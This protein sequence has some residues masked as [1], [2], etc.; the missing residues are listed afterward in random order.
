M[1]T[2]SERL[3]SSI[4]LGG[5]AATATGF[6]GVVGIA[7]D[8]AVSGGA[9]VLAGG[10]AATLTPVAVA[11]VA[12]ALIV[13]GGYFI[14]STADELINDVKASNIAKTKYTIDE[15]AN[16]VT[17]NPDN[18]AVL[19]YM[20]SGINRMFTPTYLFQAI[21]PDICKSITGMERIKG[22]TVNTIPPTTWDAFINGFDN[23]ITKYCK[24]ELAVSNWTEFKSSDD[25]NTLVSKFGGTKTAYYSICFTMA[26]SET[27][28]GFIIYRC[29][30]DK[31]ATLYPRRGGFSS[32]NAWFGNHITYK[33]NPLPTFTY[34]DTY[35]TFEAGKR[36]N[37][38][39]MPAMY[40]IDSVYSDDFIYSSA[41]TK[42]VS[43]APFNIKRNE[44]AG[45]DIMDYISEF[46]EMT[47]EKLDEFT[48]ALEGVGA[49]VDTL[50]GA[51]TDITGELEE[52]KSVALALTT[53]ITAALEREQTDVLTGEMEA[54]DVS[55]AER[56]GVDTATGAAETT[57]PTD[58]DN[59]GNTPTV[60]LPTDTGG[61]D[62]YTIYNPTA[63]QVQQF[64]KWLWEGILENIFDALKKLYQNPFDAIIA[65]NEI[66]VTPTDLTAGTINLGK[67]SSGVSANVVN[68]RYIYLLWQPMKIPE[69]YN[70]VY[71][72]DYTHIDI[73]LPF[74]GI[75][76]L[77]TA[78]IVGKTATLS[79]VVDVATGALVYNIVITDPYSGVTQLQYIF[80]GNC[81][82]QKPITG[83]NYSSMVNS[84][85]GVAA[86][87]ASGGIA[88]AGALAGGVASAAANGV[89]IQKSGAIGSNFGAMTTKTPYI[90]VTHKI[91]YDPAVFNN[92]YGYPA[93]KNVLL[94]ECTGFTRVKTIKLEGIEATE[95][96]TDEIIRL[97]KEGIYI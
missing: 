72:Y 54:V 26:L 75:Q 57:T 9:A 16:G 34:S 78:D 97:L 35:Y 65:L 83:A 29:L 31:Q 32:D 88:T 2:V 19:T 52:V 30:S 67:I 60:I 37:T 55:T 56:E 76:S 38:S 86:G 71:D 23:W 41:G 1:A 13:G 84:L 8:V 81:A 74:I 48:S 66:Y 11:A 63:T 58:P 53:D 15:E 4:L 93:N 59:A 61:N 36:F 44:A 50:T 20:Q 40:I 70:N 43:K 22:D 91:P 39:L 42:S 68:N 69:T 94:N 10:A 79:G 21:A 89:H 96:E 12:A 92:Y 64:G 14:M 24:N 28:G 62:I 82:V 45:V 49:N 80:N 5:G 51:V 17:K 73:F 3:Q 6:A 18:T 7:S 27:Y 87:V 85:L 46:G 25:Y 47:D 90:L 77:D 33:Y 95:A